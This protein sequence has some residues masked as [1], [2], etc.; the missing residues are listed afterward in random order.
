ME[1]LTSFTQWITDLVKALWQDFVNYLNDFWIGIASAF[2]SAFADL[3][4]AIPVPSFMTE[5]SFGRIYNA[6]PGDLGYFVYYL[7]LGE[8]FALIAAAFAFRM[9]RKAFTL[10]RW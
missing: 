7:N 2:L 9:T 8:A 6:L 1:W 5:Y 10:F 4:N 3:I